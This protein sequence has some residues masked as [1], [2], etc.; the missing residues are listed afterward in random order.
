M[1]I[2]FRLNN[3]VQMSSNTPQ[4]LL[5]SPSQS[6]KDAV[7]MLI[8]PSFD[9]IYSGVRPGDHVEFLQSIKLALTSQPDIRFVAQHDFSILI[10]Q[11][12][13]YK[14]LNDDELASFT[15]E[16]LDTLIKRFSSLAHL[17]DPASLLDAARTYG[18]DDEFSEFAEHYLSGSTNQ[19]KVCAQNLKKPGALIHATSK[20]HEL[21]ALAEDFIK[22]YVGVISRNP[23]LACNIEDPGKFLL[24]V[25]DNFYLFPEALIFAKTI[26]GNPDFKID[27][28][29][30]SEIKLLDDV[31]NELLLRD[32]KSHKAW[33]PIR[34]KLDQLLAHTTKVEHKE[35]TAL[36]ALTLLS[37]L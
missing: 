26:I 22:A 25:S 17:K 15:K 31:V 29:A 11:I 12:N 35:Y 32:N 16:L 36:E 8:D 5:D 19:I 20:V 23:D 9:E 2:S 37:N 34:E 21:R 24:I 18:Y 13:Q 4:P 1:N 14:I 27:E 28:L 30:H 10:A 3:G 7:N 33:S 6:F